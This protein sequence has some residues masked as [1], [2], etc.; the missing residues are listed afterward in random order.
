MTTATE[1]DNM[2]TGEVV[3]IEGFTVTAIEQ[4]N[5]KRAFD[6]SRNCNQPRSGKQVL[7]L[8]GWAKKQ[9]KKFG[10]AR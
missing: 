3:A 4:K 9:E 8:I 5:G 2:K 7:S 10:W 1:L 6:V